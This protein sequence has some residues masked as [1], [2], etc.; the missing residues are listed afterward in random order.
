MLV[1]SDGQKGVLWVLAQ[2]IAPD[3]ALLTQTQ[4][5]DFFLTIENALSK[6]PQTM[7]RQFLL[8]L[9]AIDVLSV[10]RYG[11]SLSRLDATGRSRLCRWLQEGPIGLLRNGFWGLKTLIF[12]GYY[13]RTEINEPVGYRPSKQGNTLLKR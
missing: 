13:G 5:T 4:K 1:F 11:K 8:F 9:K 6:R 10:L 12:M 7:Q 3:V 2:T